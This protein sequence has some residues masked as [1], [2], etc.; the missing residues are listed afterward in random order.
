[1]RLGWVDVDWAADPQRFDG[2]DFGE[3]WRRPGPEARTA[4]VTVGGAGLRVC[5]TKLDFV[6]RRAGIPWLGFVVYATHRRVKSRKVVEAARRITER[7]DDW[8]AGRISFAEFDAS[9]QGWVNHV[10]Y[11]DTWGLRRHVLSRFVWGADGP[12]EVLAPRDCG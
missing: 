2:F 8:G 7:Y 5:V 9:V 6:T 11:A 10:R 12:I 1:V 4:P 3:P